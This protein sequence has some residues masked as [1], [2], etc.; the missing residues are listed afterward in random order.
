MGLGETEPVESLKGLLEQ[1]IQECGEWRAEEEELQEKK[2]RRAM[3]RRRPIARR[4]GR[5]V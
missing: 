2:V 3:P 1:K 5:S 4:L